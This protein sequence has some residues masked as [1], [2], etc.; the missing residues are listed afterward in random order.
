[1]AL[2]GI[3]IA[4]F[5]AGIRR[6][7][8]FRLNF[9]VW[10]FVGIAFQLTG[11][12]FLWALLAR[13]RS[14]AG[15]TLEEIAFLYGL[16]LLA[17]ALVVFL[18]GGTQLMEFLIR[19]GNFDRYLVRPVPAL[20]LVL[21]WFRPSSIGDLAGGVVLFVVASRVAPIDLSPLAVAYLVLAVL[22]A[23]L[24]EGGIRLAIAALAFRFLRTWGV[25]WFMDNLFNNFG[26]LPLRIFGG[27]VE[28]VLTFVVPVAFVAYVPASVVLGRT[29]E[30]AILPGL[31]YV[32]PLVGVVVFGLAYLLWRHELPQYQSSG[33]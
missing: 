14:I 24:I 32:A 8:Q 30:L 20:V 4:L 16:R 25:L 31:A 15:W 21:S 10:V 29:S 13:F 18:F 2:A 7:L 19:E 1:M 27:L 23:I 17:H 22:G 9:V 12:F 26:N 5:L 3:S 33:H 28:F 11:F 6:E